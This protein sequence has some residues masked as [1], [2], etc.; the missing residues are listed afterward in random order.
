M[1]YHD[2][3][4]DNDY[5]LCAADDEFNTDRDDDDNGDDQDAQIMRKEERI[6]QIPPDVIRQH[7]KNGKRGKWFHVDIY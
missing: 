7:L 2:D 6:P 1:E 5:A 4:S 3:S